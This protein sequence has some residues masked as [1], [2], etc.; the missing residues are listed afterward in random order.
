MLRN[1]IPLLLVCLLPATATFGAAPI[2]L[3]PAD[4]EPPTIDVISSSETGASFIFELP[5]LSVVERTVDGETFQVVSIP[6][7]GFVGVDGEPAI[8]TYQKMIAVPE[9]A[10]IRV[11]TTVL[12][13][14]VREGMRLFPMPEGETGAFAYKRAAYESGGFAK[15]DLRASVGEVGI[16]RDF[17]VAPIAFEPV[18]YNASSG[19]MKVARRMQVDIEFIGAASKSAAVGN[20]SIIPTSFHNLYRNNV[21]NYAGPVEGQAVA[22]GTWLIICPNSTGVVDSLQELVDWR[23]R[24]GHTVLLATTA[25]TG[26][27]TTSIKNYIQS[28]Y[29]DPAHSLEY[30][31]LAGDASGSYQIATYFEG[32]SGYNGEGDHPYTQLAGG[33]ILADVHIG[34][35]SFSTMNELKLIVNKTVNYESTPEVGDNTWYRRACL[36]GDP[37]SSG[38]SCIIA[39]EWV[40]ERLVPY[41]YDL[42]SLITS[43]NFVSQMSSVLNQGT[44]IMGYRG[45]LGMSG[46]SNAYS[47]TTTNGWKLPY[48]VIITC[49]TGSFASGTSRSEGFLRAGSGHNSP[50]GAVGAVGTSTIGTHTR[51][52]NS[53]YYGTFRGLLQEGMTTMGAS[54]TRGKLELYMNYIMAESQKVTI[55]SYWNNLIGDPA[56]D[57]WTN[58]PENLTVTHPASVQ[59]GETYVA[60]NVME[61]ASP[62]ENAQVC[63]WKGAEVH[64][65]RFTDGAGNIDIPVSSLTAG[66]LKLTVTKHN[67]QPYLADI[68]VASATDLVTHI[69]A[70]IDDDTNGSSSGNNDGI[71]TASE[72][73]ELAVQLQNHGSV[74]HTSIVGTLSSSDPF[75]TIT[76]AVESYGSVNAGNTQWGDDDFDYTVD[77]GCP[78]GHVIGLDLAV[79][80]A[81]GSWTSLIEQTVSSYSLT[82]LNSTVS[83]GGNGKLDPGETANVSFQIRNDG[84]Y[85]GF[86]LTG[87]LVSETPFVTVNDGLASF[88][89]A[90]S[91]GGLAD[92][93][94]D[95]FSLTASSSAYKGM[96][97]SLT[98]YT[99]SGGGILDTVYISLVIGSAATVD[100]TGPDSY[101]YFAFD[102]VDVAYSEAPTYSWIELD[103]S[104]GGDGTEIPMGDNG[105]YQDETDVLQLPFT[106]QYY[107]ES[108]DTVSVC[109]NGWIAM[110]STD[111][112]SYRNWTIPGAGGP[113]GMI[114]PFWENLYQTASSKVFQKYDTVNHT[115]IVEWSRF[116][117]DYDGSTV[118]FEAILFDPAFHPYGS[119]DGLIRFQYNQVSNNDPVNGYATV[120]IESPDQLDGILITYFNKY[121]AGSASLAAGRAIDFV[122]IASGPLGTVSGF[123]YN[124]SNGNS[125]A[126]GVSVEVLGMGQT[127]TSAADGSY[128]GLVTPGSYTLVASGGGFAPDT[129]TGVTIVESATTQ[130]DFYLI[131]NVAPVI[132]TTTQGSTSDSTGPY[133]IHVTI[134]EGSGLAEK[135]L[136][137]RRNSD[138][139]QALPLVSQGGDNYLADIPGQPYT[140]MVEYY[141]YA[142]DTGDLQGYDPPG[143]KTSPYS[144]VVGELLPIFADDIELDMGW[145]LGDAG[146]NASTGVWVREEPVGTYNGGPEI[147]PEYDHT[148]DPAD[149][150]FV[151]GNATSGAAYGTNDVDGGK[152]TLLSP[153][154]DLSNYATAEV[155]YWSWYTNDQGSNP[156]ADTWLVEVTDDGI[157]WPDLENTTTSTNAW[158]NRTFI[159]D[160]YISLTSTVQFR[161]IASDE[162]SGSIVEAAVDDFLLTGLDPVATGVDA[163]EPAGRIDFGLAPCRPNPFNPTTL[164]SYNLPQP[165]PVELR[166]FDI[167]GR[168]VKVLAN[169]HQEA[170][171]HN[172]EW[173]GMSSSGRPVAAGVYFVRLDAKGFMQVRQMTLIR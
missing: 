63:L 93:A 46:W 166:I 171:E 154:F 31:V 4:G 152:T 54:L 94:A 17:R 161:F 1:P 82:H 109:S 170:G 6:G 41:D 98:L 16:L 159:L 18:R 57:V 34:R 35:L 15:L 9:G 62:L 88:G 96:L 128:S 119:G 124:A 147:Q 117:N 73:I 114:A 136:Y 56:V 142:K 91:G 27:N 135:I 103:P 33:D 39:Q 105:Q 47:Y 85:G 153:V 157:S 66:A 139:F 77:P 99:S 51:Y 172:V 130:R 74:D 21:I 126:E 97:A 14:E 155:S 123:T 75:V 140:S 79:D 120:G 52:N 70:T 131:D 113:R 165:G 149:I 20:N 45:W 144:F 25:Q 164:I 162:G 146:D 169:R 71:V 102:D 53:C 89:S 112:V 32:L 115:W 80:A 137:Y 19:E 167:T 111:L 84:S 65:V 10:E 40:A 12:M 132:T 83:D 67:K 61:G 116:R 23:T 121:S 163:T 86:N 160:D 26:T 60:I 7:G 125:P 87:T 110:G 108:F 22:P 100:P 42:I 49:D 95:P 90:S 13:E 81:L 138:P 5:E 38:L 37:S 29:D 2:L 78:D 127:F 76:D 50:A 107:G 43:S 59:L 24:K 143:G 69:A 173:N 30:V 156:G 158:V 28:V 48:A 148:S 104:Y 55:W 151:T 134:V 129:A 64:E 72:S 36:V 44:T 122:P 118:T 8:P 58:F 133:P 101:G 168:E 150:C 92:N 3:E 145:T 106:F 11:S 68:S 141:V